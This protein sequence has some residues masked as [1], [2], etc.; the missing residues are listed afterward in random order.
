MGAGFQ[1]H[2]MSLDYSFGLVTQGDFDAVHKV[3][4][5]LRFENLRNKNRVVYQIK[6]DEKPGEWITVPVERSVRE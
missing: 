4:F 1:F 6:P 3:N 5:G 2:R